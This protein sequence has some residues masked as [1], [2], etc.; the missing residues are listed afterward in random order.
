[1]VAVVV[2]AKFYYTIHSKPALLYV[3]EE[4]YNS[5]N[6]HTKQDC[7]R[8]DRAKE[9]RVGKKFGIPSVQNATEEHRYG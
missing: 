7:T 9:K 6:G 1:V 8:L 5:I 3:S 2:A 4:P